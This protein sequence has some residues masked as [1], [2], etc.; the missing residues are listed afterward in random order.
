LQNKK[1]LT[2]SRQLGVIIVG[3]F[4]VKEEE[5]YQQPLYACY[6]FG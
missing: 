2:S 5:I 3:I 4:D 6:C 1:Q